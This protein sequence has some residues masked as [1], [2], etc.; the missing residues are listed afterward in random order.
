MLNYEL[1]GKAIAV[2]LQN[3][4]SIIAFVKWNKEKEKNIA[5]LYLQDNKIPILDLIEECEHLVLPNTNKSTIKNDM[6]MFIE[7]CFIS[8]LFDKYIE[9][10]KFQQKCFDIGVEQLNRQK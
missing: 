10:F 6:T 8:G 4:Y 2:D 9:R 7:K 5:T 1:L 3:G